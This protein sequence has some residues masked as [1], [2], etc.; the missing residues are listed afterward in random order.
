M[1]LSSASY[2]FEVKYTRNRPGEVSTNLA[3]CE[4]ASVPEKG[5]CCTHDHLMD[6]PL[7]VSARDDQVAVVFAVV[8]PA[9]KVGDLFTG[10]V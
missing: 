8:G 3:Y 10:E 9:V 5:G 1:H 4:V 2:R 7:H 6:N